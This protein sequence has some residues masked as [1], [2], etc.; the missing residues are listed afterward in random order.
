MEGSVLKV[1]QVKGNSMTSLTVN[2]T[3]TPPTALFNGKASIMDITNPAAPVSVGG[4]YTLQVSMT[5]MGE[6]GSNDKIGIT[7]FNKDGGI[8]YTS[9]WDGSKTIQQTLGGGNLV[10][11]GSNV[12]S[13]P[14]ARAETGNPAQTVT[15]IPNNP[16]IVKVYGNPTE[17][18]FNINIQGSSEK[19]S[20]RVIDIRGRVIE[21][22]EN[23]PQG[24]LQLGQLYQRGFYYLEVW[25]G[26]KIRQLKLVKL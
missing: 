8:W 20:L 16:F 26:N 25:Q 6:P 3:A 12:G 23:V 5:D 7:V 2:G 10:V 21:W 19:I 1:Y 22:R 9:N 13:T 24:T 14:I 11:H 18:H 4:N 15:T 17:D